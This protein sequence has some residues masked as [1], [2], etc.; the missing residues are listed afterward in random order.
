MN[1][2]LE[3]LRASFFFYLLTTP[4]TFLKIG[5]YLPA[6]I[7]IGVALLFGGLQL[8]VR[9]GWRQV[10]QDDKKRGDNVFEMK[11]RSTPE[12]RETRSRPV[13]GALSVMLATHVTGAILFLIVN[14]TQKIDQPLSITQTI[15]S[16]VSRH[17]S[18]GFIVLG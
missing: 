18:I 1:N 4:M 6:P 13:L 17:R 12:Q 2:L 9:A 14:R 15:V 7:L 10:A 5:L 11:D 3:R 16:L 8:W